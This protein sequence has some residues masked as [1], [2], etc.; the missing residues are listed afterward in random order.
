MNVSVEHKRILSPSWMLSHIRT[1]LGHPRLAPVSR[2]SG[3]KRPTRR[4]DPAEVVISDSSRMTRSG[5]DAVWLGKW[6]ELETLQFFC[7]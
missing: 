2:P 3:P 1:P 7:F 6:M 5:N 4:L